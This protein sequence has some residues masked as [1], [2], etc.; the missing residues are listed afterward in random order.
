MLQIPKGDKGYNILFTILDSTGAAFN[1]TDYTVTFKAWRAN[2]PNT[3]IISSACS[4]VSGSGGTCNY[5]PTA[6]DTAVAGTYMA[7]IELTKTG[8]IG[9]TIPLELKI[10]ESG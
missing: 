5:S 10:T 4:I 9:S 6:A 7:E 2:T 1:I 8:I 3:L